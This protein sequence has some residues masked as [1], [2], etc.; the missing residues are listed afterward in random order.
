MSRL[1]PTDA[2]ALRSFPRLE[3]SPQVLWRIHNSDRHPA[4][5]SSTGNYRFDPPRHSHGEFGTCYTALD[6]LG[7][8][9]ETFGRLNVIPQHI[10][11]TKVI[12]ELYLAKP[13]RIADLTAP[14]IAGDF[15][16][17]G[18]ISTGAEYDVP[19][20]WA[21]ALRGA[22]FDGVHYI[23]RHDP[24]GDLRSVA[25]FGPPGEQPSLFQELKAAVPIPR[26]LVEQAKS[27]FH[28]TI[29][30]TAPLL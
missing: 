7:A 19:Q 1:P 18:D 28:V 25:L 21:S 15:G 24:S 6:P 3:S 29:I 23:A 26:D 16:I 4:F 13:V 20:L 5:F 14:S 9:M 10:V 8:F 17:Y 11:D 22:G 30:P 2:D 27:Y 12:S